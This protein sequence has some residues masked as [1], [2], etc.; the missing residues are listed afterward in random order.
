MYRRANTKWTVNECLRLER[1]WDLLELSVQDIAL[2]HERSP[3]SIMYKL[4][5][6]G[7]ADYNY[8]F[9]NR[10]RF[11]NKHQDKENNQD[12]SD[13]DSEYNEGSEQDDDVED[14]DVDVDDEYVDEEVDDDYD[15]YNIKQQ[16]G[17]ITQQLSDL[18]MFV[19]K[20]LSPKGKNGKINYSDLAGC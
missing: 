18:T 16:I 9:M 19:Y 1:E 20:A 11:N 7:I 15:V 4:D 12:Q 17:L 5:N 2:L 8:V 3:E 6:E 10:Q 13:N 14:V